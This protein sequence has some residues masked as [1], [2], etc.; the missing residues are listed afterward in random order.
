MS[1]PHSVRALRPLKSL[2]KLVIDNLGIDSRK[3]NFVSSSTAYEENNGA[4]VVAK[5]PSITPT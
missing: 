4:I 5:S 2:I 1:L 3:M